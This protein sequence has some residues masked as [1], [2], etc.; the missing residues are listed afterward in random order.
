MG[1]NSTWSEDTLAHS[2][3]VTYPCCH[4]KSHS[5][6]RPTEPPLW[7]APG[8]LS[9]NHSPKK[10]LPTFAAFIQT[11]PFILRLDHLFL[12]SSFHL[13]I[14]HLSSA[15]HVLRTVVGTQDLIINKE[16]FHPH[17]AHSSVGE[18]DKPTTGMNSNIHQDSVAGLV[19]RLSLFSQGPTLLDF[20]LT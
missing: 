15:C 12:H 2:M 8:F 11:F 17:R 1:P 13:F 20:R 16:K 18:R 4:T 7:E 10:S 9:T 5:I 6:H 3:T 14:E 19:L